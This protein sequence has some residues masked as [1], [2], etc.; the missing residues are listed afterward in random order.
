MFLDFALFIFENLLDKQQNR[1]S[2]A[3]VMHKNDIF[4]TGKRAPS[5]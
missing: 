5:R 2:T 4:A 1:R 3:A